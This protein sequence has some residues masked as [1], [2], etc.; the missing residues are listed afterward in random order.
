MMI[1][2]A[3]L[4]NPSKYL[5]SFIGAPAHITNK[6]GIRVAREEVCYT[7]NHFLKALQKS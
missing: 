7:I 5:P 3:Y 2:D 1:V 6:N 4:V